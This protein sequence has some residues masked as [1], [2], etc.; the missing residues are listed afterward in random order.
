MRPWILLGNPKNRRVSGFCEALGRAGQRFAVCSWADFLDD[1]SGLVRVAGTLGPDGQDAFLRVDSIGEDA[2]VEQRL[3]RLGAGA[4]RAE[5]V[6]VAT[7]AEIEALP[8]QFGR[9]LAPR[10][11]HL[12]FL[13]ALDLLDRVISTRPGWV[14]LNPTATTRLCFDKRRSSRR[15]V[16]LGVPVPRI[17]TVGSGGVRTPGDDTLPDPGAHGLVIK[18]ASGSS[19]SCLG[20]WRNAPDPQR[21]GP[22]SRG[23]ELF[24]SIERARDGLYNS[25][26]PRTYVGAP[27]RELVRML[28]REGAHVE[29]FVPKALLDGQNFD[30]RVLLV[31]GEPAFTLV[32]SSPHPVTNLHLGGSRGD[33]AQ[34]GEVVRA[35]VMDAVH[36]S[37][38]LI[39]REIPALHLGVDV[40]IE[41]EPAPGSPG[42]RVL[43]IN[44]FGDL[45]PNLERHEEGR[46]WSVYDWEIRAAGGSLG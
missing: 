3:L 22:F 1:V 44:A 8:Q 11:L 32:R 27:A 14:V 41:A 39:G 33:P 35:G 9:I 12:G 43:E 13:A 46:A 36:K 6:W 7:P 23:P 37:M 29:E 24:T 42:F 25:L 4:A 40:M 16:E 18:L 17:V 19:A 15:L 30:L 5:G 2:A 31:A 21:R 45:L 34:L 28:L 26:R 10:Q 20:I 38:R